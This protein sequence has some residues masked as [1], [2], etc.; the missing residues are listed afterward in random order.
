MDIQ[1]LTVGSTLYLPVEVPGALF[2]VSDSH[3]S[4]GNGEVDLTAIEGSMRAAVRLTVIKRG[5]PG[6]PFGGRL[7]GPFA[8]NASAWFPIGLSPDLNDAM[9]G[10]VR[11]GVEFLVDR[12]DMTPT[13]AYAYLSIGANF[14]VSEVVAATK[15]IHGIILK[16]DFAAVPRAI[17]G[18]RSV[19]M[20]RTVPVEK[21]RSSP[22]V[23]HRSSTN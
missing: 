10:A 21:S 2:Y 16:S 3:F 7:Q 12:F 17:P 5:T 13:E 11:Q 23:S 6:A 1:D 20:E 9:R 18:R 15:G 14:D 19:P 22:S 4:Q 8:E